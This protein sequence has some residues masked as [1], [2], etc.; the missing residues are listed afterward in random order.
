MQL[1]QVGVG[2]D[3][4]QVGVGAEVELLHAQAPQGDDHQLV[5]GRVV[6][7]GRGMR[8]ADQLKR[9]P[10]AGGD[11]CVGQG[12][13]ALERLKHGGLEADRFGLEA[14]HLA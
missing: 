13:G 2:Q 12:R 4:N 14:E 7:I 11:G 10:E 6:E 1:G 3:K 8:F 5:P 9:Q